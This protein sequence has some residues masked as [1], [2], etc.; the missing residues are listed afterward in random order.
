MATRILN[1]SITSKQAAWLENKEEQGRRISPSKLLQNAIAD[2]MSEED[3]NSSHISRRELLRR[4]EEMQKL[5]NAY[6]DATES[7][8]DETSHKLH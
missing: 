7:N 1:V 5:F 6:R 2:I 3:T 4:F 8:L